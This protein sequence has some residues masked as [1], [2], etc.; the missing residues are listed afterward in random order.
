MEIL[1]KGPGKS[2]NFLG[3]DVGGGNS[4]GA[5]AKI[6]KII[7]CFICIYEKIAGGG[8]PHPIVTAVLSLYFKHCWRTTGSLKI[9]LGSWKS[10]GNFCSQKSGNPVGKTT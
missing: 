9:L 7:S 5:D 4:A 10:P 6:A 8:A 3:Y 1:V 2:W